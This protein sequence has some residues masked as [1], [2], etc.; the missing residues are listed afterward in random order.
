MLLL[1][2]ENEILKRHITVQNKK[3]MFSRTDRFIFSVIQSLSERALGHLTLLKPETLIRWQKQFIKNLW[4]YK[5][6]KMAGHISRNQ[7]RNLF[8][9]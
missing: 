8:L 3:L 2:K 1:K 5:S 4:T 7:L 6:T 9:K